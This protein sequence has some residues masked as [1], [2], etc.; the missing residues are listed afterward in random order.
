MKPHPS[1]RRLYGALFAILVA[2]FV[3][4]GVGDSSARADT[5]ITVCASSCDYSS[6]Q[7]AIAAAGSGDT[8]DVSGNYSL[9]STVTIDKSVT[10]QGESDTTISADGLNSAFAV[11]AD[12][13]TIKGFSFVTSS[14]IT[15]NGFVDITTDADSATVTDNTFKGVFSFG[16]SHVTRGLVV[17]PGV[18]G[19]TITDN[20]F[21][22][23]RQPAYIDNNDSGTVSGN[24]AAGTKGWV[25]GAGSSMSFSGNTWGTST[26]A[27]DSQKNAVDI[28][29]ITNASSS[30]NYSDVA[31][32]SQANNDAVIDN[33][34]EH[35]LSVAY[36]DA[37]AS[38]GGNGYWNSP[39]QTVQ[40]AVDAV[41]PGGTVNVASG[42]YNEDVT[43]SKPVSLQGSNATVKSF[44]IN[45]ASNVTVDGFT[46]N[47]AGPQ[48]RV[49]SLSGPTLSGI[50]VSGNVFS[51][52][53]DVAVPTF[54]AGNIN[55][56]GNTFENPSGSAEAIQIKANASTSGGCSGST[57]QN[58]TF[59]SA[60]NNGGADVNFSCTGSDSSGISVSRNTSTGTSG[61]SSFLGLSGVTSLRTWNN[62]ATT[63]GSTVFVFG[64]ITGT[65][66]STNDSFTSSTGK[67][68]S[69]HAAD[70][71][72]DP[73]NSGTID[74][75]NGA[76]SG[77][78]A[79]GISSGAV[80]SGTV[81]KVHGSKITGGVQNDASSVMTV[82][83][84]GNWWGS[85]S[86]PGTLAG[87][88]AG[89]PCVNSSCTTPP[90]PD[91]GGGGNTG[92]N[93][94]GNAGGNS[95]GGGN[96]SNSGGGNSGGGGGGGAPPTTTTTPPN[97]PAAVNQPQSTPAA[98]SQPGSVAVT[99]VPTTTNGTPG[100]APP[101]SVATTWS[102][103]TFTVP[104]TVTVT[105][106][107]EAAVPSK[108]GPGSPPKA[109]AGGFAVGNTVISLT[110]TTGSGTAV[111]S[112]QEPIKIH[113]SSFPPA[114]TPA[115]SH[116]GMSWTT[117][118]RLFS[119]PLPAG[120]QDGYFVNPDGSVDIYTT[121]ATLFGFL[122]DK[123]APSKVNLKARRRGKYVY[124]LLK[125]SKDNV[126][127][128]HYVVLLNGR[129]VKTTKHGYNRLV[130]RKGRY[131]VVA[132]DVA[133]NRSKP[134][135]TFVVR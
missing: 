23:V 121:H 107:P 57:V 84:T 98:P 63:D 103:G 113:V 100:T 93:S 129:V 131:Q 80:N 2:A 64:D 96:S 88:N 16:D 52:Y 106:Q 86:G 28:A 20:Q 48:L 69:V 68:I 41:M 81:V 24:F 19:L 54:N 21:V 38:S 31:A 101:V 15:N 53:K 85:A 135:N 32:L 78:P 94:G 6:I 62:T 37:N 92:N 102:P 79:L 4:A 22:S 117:I 13:V 120:Q 61:G 134:S 111:T 49:E 35:E 112:F 11:S 125:G 77:S 90:P 5:T 116:D 70:I 56:T 47:N 127:V 3:A 97:T 50:S 26:S 43:V 44:D 17:S 14:D 39:F 95:D 60:T 89:S 66:A 105:P 65:W 18:S 40:D 114:E 36:A 75:E 82:D 122:L 25:V 30:D 72:S 126:R 108:G 8:I 119:L 123:Q 55:L 91:N 71:T 109:V 34:F 115:Y 12:S 45:G 83:A 27:G 7:D 46:F 42:T 124:L 10:L 128:D 59:N 74:V 76:L 73:V 87:V 133:G 1:K 51:G 104:V 132:Y 110:V 9:S 99:V 33:Q 58:N 130:A 118:P 67:A 29:I